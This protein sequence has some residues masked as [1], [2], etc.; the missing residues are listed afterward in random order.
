[1]PRKTVSPSQSIKKKVAIK[2]A[3]KKSPNNN[4]LKIKRHFTTAED[5][6]YAGIT[7][8]RRSSSI[9]EPDGTV[10]FELNDI[11][12]PSSWS[13]L[14]V[15]I[16]A[17]K[18]IRKAGVPKTG[19]EVSARQ[20]VER[21]ATTVRGYA[22][23]INAFASPA[24]S[25]AFEDELIHL[26]INQKAAF[27]SPVWFNLGLYHSYN[28]TNGS[29]GNYYW[30]TDTQAI[31]VTTNNYEH[32]QC[33]ACF[34]QSVDDD[35]TSIFSLVNKEAR[36]FKF[37]SGTGTNFSRLRGKGEKLSG[38][39]SS[40]GAMS[41]LEVL[42]RAAGSI[43]SGGTTR[44]AAKMAIMD[45]DHP[46]IEVFIN[47]KVNEEK[48]VAAMVAAGYSSDF[49]GE[50]YH[51]VSGQ[52]S[53]NSVRVTDEFMEAVRKD[54]DW[55]LRARTTG[56]VMKTIK[57]RDLMN[58]ISFAAWA[59]ADPGLQF[60][61]TINSWHTAADTDRIYASNPCSE[62]MFLDDTACNLASLNLMK[63]VKEDGKLDVKSYVEANRIIFMA[64]E[65]M[66]DLSSY[67][68]EEIAKNSH[69]Y[70]PLGLGYANLGT[71]L[72][73]QG[74]PYD[75][76]GGRATAAAVTSIM[77]ATG[78][79]TSAEIASVIGTYP[80]YEK[81]KKSMAKVMEKHRKAAQMLDDSLTPD[82]L[83]KAA[84]SLSDEMVELGQKYGY[85]N[86]QA[87]VLAPTGTIG[88]LMDC[89]TTGVEPEFSLVKWKK[90][91]GGGMFKIVNKSITKALELLGYNE[92]ETKEIIDYILGKGT[93][94]D[95]PHIS[96]SDLLKLGF[97]EDQIKAASDY[98][99]SY[100]TLDDYTPEVNPASLKAV[101]LTD[102]QIEAAQVYISGAQTVEG[103]PILK[104]EHYAVF[105]C[106]NRCGT[107]ERYIE[108]MGHVRM[109]AAVQP[110]LSGAISKTVNMPNE[111]TVE[112]VENIYMESWKL[113]LK[114]IALYRDG[115][116]L[117]Q[118]LN[119]K[120]S[121]K[122]VVEAEDSVEALEEVVINTNQGVAWGSRRYLPQ[123][124]RG[125]TL[126]SEIGGQEI[127][128]RTGEY[129]NGE[130]GEIFISG[131]KEGATMR[132][133]LDSFAVAISI[134]LQ[135]GVP[136]ENYVNKFTFTRF[137]P[138][139]MT[140]HPN[141][142]TA[143]SLVDF[144][145]RVLGMEYLGR[146]DFAHVPPTPDQLGVPSILTDTPET[147]DQIVSTPEVSTPSPISNDPVAMN[148][149][150]KQLSDMMG[151]A[152]LCNLCGHITVRNGSCYKCLSCGNSMG[153]S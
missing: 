67:P 150:D 130:L 23:S 20:V 83:A 124:R 15:D 113:G 46:E 104:E 28:I 31:E 73:C 6:P 54:K 38:G 102:E 134:G 52:N 85:R 9:T 34:I 35:L 50:A 149:L 48:K 121:K 105:D 25:Q 64:Q 29:G 151:D 24:D 37:G 145:F 96:P 139:G 101:G 131:F 95:A 153:C 78:Y 108:P 10:V 80:A 44:R 56:E 55:E 116:K 99:S 19:H 118:P 135:H 11:E 49:N 3:T 144:I 148:A 94:D 114:A 8:E 45:V 103:S 84:R 117:S 91:V 26:L 129:E 66:V 51:T 89:D 27:N 138:S 71:M 128:L 90:L 5:G 58:Q 123:K 110:F 39:G 106:A 72:M 61:T 47:W 13:Q 119:S 41:F 21:I 43:K 77:N 88:L 42:D 120:K 87:T 132:S 111:T 1:M 125:F 65:F 60:D 16:L 82:Y 133:L 141:I 122:D 74:L 53:N 98:V 4:G 18:Y 127:Y 115:C 22:D 86:A 107:G 76:D 36:L 92:L 59:C 32:P 109:M 126:K 57:A 137:E 81:N 2:T 146:T 62:F 69:A 63:F 17:S 40:S 70:R 30:D 14:A 136:L 97:S 147:S 33:S 68:G 12:V 100:K 7:W 75:S 93:L 79:R 152:P 112:E 143:T 140:N 142:K